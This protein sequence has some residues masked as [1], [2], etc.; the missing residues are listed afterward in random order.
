MC[1]NPKKILPPTHC[2]ACGAIFIAEPRSAGRQRYCAR[3]SC[4]KASRRESQRR[5]QAKT[6]NYSYH[7]GPE[8]TARVQA[9]RAAHPGYWRRRRSPKEPAKEL[10]NLGSLLVAFA[11]Q[12]SCDALQDSWTPHLV[13]LIGLIARLRGSALQDIIADELTEVMLAGHAILESIPRQP[14][15]AS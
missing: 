5:W 12:D 1:L 10:R 6:A 3:L 7:A 11:L 8:H 9:W 2:A 14:K 15:P 13:A 4:R